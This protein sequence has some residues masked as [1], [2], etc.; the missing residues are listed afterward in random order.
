MF[1]VSTK[2]LRIRKN[3]H[4]YEYKWSPN[5]SNEHIVYNER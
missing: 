1:S 4:K 5:I 3:L 2:N